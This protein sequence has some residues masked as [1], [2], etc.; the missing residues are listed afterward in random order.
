MQNHPQQHFSAYSIA[1]LLILMCWLPGIAKIFKENLMKI[2]AKNLRTTQLFVKVNCY[3]AVMQ[4]KKINER[5]T[6]RLR[7]IIESMEKSFLASKIKGLLIF[8]LLTMQSVFLTNYQ[9]FIN[10]GTLR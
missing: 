3:A 6:I 5:E 10:I 2:E 7:Y 9:I 8:V 1:L 4:Y